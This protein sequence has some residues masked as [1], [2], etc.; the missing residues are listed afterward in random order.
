MCAKTSGAFA[1]PPTLGDATVEALPSTAYYIPSFISEEEER[2]ILEKV[3]SL[4]LA[5]SSL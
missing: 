4:F 1:L 5:G 3:R 2:A